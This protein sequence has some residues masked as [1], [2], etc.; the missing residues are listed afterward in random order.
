MHATHTP[1]HPSTPAACRLY[2]RLLTAC[3]QGSPTAAAAMHDQGARAAAHH[4]ASPPTPTSTSPLLVRPRSPATPAPP[5]AP[6][7]GYPSSSCTSTYNYHAYAPLLAAPSMYPKSPC[8]PSRTPLSRPYSA[9]PSV[10]SVTPMSPARSPFARSNAT[11][12]V[13]PPHSPP[14]RSRPHSPPTKL[15]FHTNDIISAP[16]K[17][18]EYEL[19]DAAVEPKVRGLWLADV[20]GNAGFPNRTCCRYACMRV[21]MRA[22]APGRR[23]SSGLAARTHAG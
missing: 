16:P 20:P 18:L 7:T 1:T 17:Y 14:P 4:G 9:A 12:P 5:A 15:K 13:P 2:D 11:A 10:M 3:Y 8:H 21:G 22:C 19:P 23:P 6:A